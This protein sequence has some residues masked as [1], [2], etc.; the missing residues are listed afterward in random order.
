MNVPEDIFVQIWPAQLNGREQM[1]TDA[2][3]VH[4]FLAS[5]QKYQ[6]WIKNRI[7]MYGFEEG[8]DH[9]SDRVITQVPHQGS[10]RIT[11]VMRYLVSLDMA[12]E[13][14]MVERTEMGKRVRGYFID[15]ERQYQANLQ[16]SQLCDALIQILPPS[17]DDVDED[18][19]SID[20][21]NCD[22]HAI[23]RQAQADVAGENAQRFHRR[24]EALL[25]KQSEL[26]RSLKLRRGQ[27]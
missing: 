21:L 22:I 23:N 13:L 16:E 8:K 12:K 27:S 26:L 25:E 11:P 15:C 2:Q 20:L 7:R 14:A 6:H 5:K 4:T 1:V 18:R 3:Q 19:L 24:R 10:L 17:L 9:L